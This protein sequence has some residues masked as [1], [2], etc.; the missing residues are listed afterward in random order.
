MSAR[1]YILYDE[2][3][4][5]DTDDAQVVEAGIDSLAEAHEA[6]RDHGWSMVCYSYKVEGGYLVDERFEFH[7]VEGALVG[8]NPDPKKKK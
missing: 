6:A 7:H 8:K 3:A 1:H 5:E 4:I 2:R